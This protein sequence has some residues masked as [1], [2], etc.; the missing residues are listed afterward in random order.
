MRPSPADIR[1]RVDPGDVPAAKAARR[2][3]LLE[4]DFLRMLP[5]LLARGFPPADPTTGMFDLNAIEVW[6][7][8]RNPRLFG[9]TP[10]VTN[11]EPPRKVDMGE[12]FREAQER[13]RHG[14]SA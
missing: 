5:E 13:R 7:R 10:L 11:E 3:H 14:R 2:L 8:S 4:A 6:R 9:L 12:R 1:Y